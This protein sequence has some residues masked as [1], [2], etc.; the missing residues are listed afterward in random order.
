MI[1]LNKPKWLTARS[2]EN[3]YAVLSMVCTGAAITKLATQPKVHLSI[4][5]APVWQFIAG[6]LAAGLFYV[7]YHAVDGGTK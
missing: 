7:L 5:H 2:A 4:G 3:A 1:S 6:I